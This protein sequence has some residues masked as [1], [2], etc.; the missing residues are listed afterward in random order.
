MLLHG[1]SYPIGVTRPLGDNPVNP[2]SR[3]RALSLSVIAF[4]ARL[5]LLC[6]VAWHSVNAVFVKQLENR[7]IPL[8]Q[9]LPVALGLDLMLNQAPNVQEKHTHVCTQ[10]GSASQSVTL[11]HRQHK[12][13][14]DASPW[15]LFVLFFYHGLFKI[16]FY[17]FGILS[18]YSVSFYFPQTFSAIHRLQ[19]WAAGLTKGVVQLFDSEGEAAVV[20]VDAKEDHG[21]VL[22]GAAGGSRRRRGAVVRVAL[23]HR[24][25]VV[26]TAGE[27]LSLQDPA[28]KH[29][30]EEMLY[31]NFHIN[32]PPK[33][34]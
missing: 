3:V 24:E 11:K 25:L 29:L 6:Y 19:R 1:Q 18:I 17:N 12:F 20:A 2:P 9:S 31:F 14:G 10:A 15:S 7:C 23:V 32:P 13:D 22:R 34:S 21:D 28:V 30:E 4:A 26:L 8:I 16:L 5:G 33:N 27:L